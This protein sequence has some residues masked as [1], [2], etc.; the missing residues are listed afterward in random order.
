MNGSSGF[1]QPYQPEPLCDPG[2]IP[3][4]SAQGRVLVAWRD[5]LRA[6][7][8]PT[9]SSWG[10]GDPCTFSWGGVSCENGTVVGVSLV[11]PPADPNMGSVNGNMG[12]PR[13][14]A[15]GPVD[16]QSLANLTR[17]RS[18]GLQVRPSPAC[19]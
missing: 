10:T 19:M 12:I 18:L 1:Y 14:Y 7:I 6:W 3:E 13:T 5:S 11:P 4:P 17:L 15:Q 8:N 16:W 9:L 2:R